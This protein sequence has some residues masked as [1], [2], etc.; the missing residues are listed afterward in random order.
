MDDSAFRC[1]NLYLGQRNR[2]ALKRKPW[3]EY[4]RWAPY[5]SRSWRKGYTGHHD[6]MLH[7]FDRIAC[8]FI[9]TVQTHFFSLH[10]PICLIDQSTGSACAPGAKRTESLAH[11]TNSGALQSLDMHHQSLPYISISKLYHD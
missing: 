8:H 10:L 3:H 11:G 4:S 5:S 6:Q 9:Y 2:S 7:Q 1:S